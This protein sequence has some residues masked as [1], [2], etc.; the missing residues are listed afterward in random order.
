MPPRPQV[1]VVAPSYRR[2]GGLA[3]L[4]AALVAQEAPGLDWDAVI[5]DN[6]P[7]RGARAQVEGAR[8]SSPVPIAYVHEPAL[9]AAHARNRGIAEATGEIIAMIDDDVVP[10]RDWLARL[11]EPILAGR[12]D[13]TGGTVLLDPEVPRPSW[14]DERGIGGYV[15][16]WEPAHEERPLAEDEIV[17]TANAA[18]RAGRL[19]AVGGFNPALG[20]RGKVHVVGEDAL[21]TREFAAAG[22]RVHYVPAAVVTHAFPPSRRQPWPVLRTAYYHGRSDWILDRQTLETRRLNGARVAGS[23]LTSELRARARE[24][25]ARRPV[26]FHAACDL[27]RMAGRLREAV[28]WSVTG[29]AA[30]RA[31]GRAPTAASAEHRHE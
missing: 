24:G 7:G 29:R 5:V 18:W 2:P 13:A 6:D 28:T 8:S 21:L 22:G 11:V 31:P 20:P 15:A 14:W 16:Y 26:V 17:I 12:C 9:G 19:R 1:T 23:W 27:A 25:F 3:R 10:A 4:L 30:G